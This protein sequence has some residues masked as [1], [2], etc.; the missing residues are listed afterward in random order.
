[1]E[2]ACVNGHM[3]CVPSDTAAIMT[4]AP[5]RELPRRA[6]CRPQDG[7]SAIEW[8]SKSY[9]GDAIVPMNE[10]AFP[11]GSIRFPPTAKASTPLRADLR[12]I[13][14]GKRSGASTDHSSPPSGSGL[15]M[16]NDANGGAGFD[17]G[18]PENPK[19]IPGATKRPSL[20]RLIW[21]RPVT[22]ANSCHCPRGAIRSRRQAPPLPLRPT[23]P[24]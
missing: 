7:P 15:Q 13:S 23:C 10:L 5:N 20:D 9:I 16:P 11:S 19:P 17:H 14:H 1:M 8:I 2:F 22:I 18:E 21:L 12:G 6:R 24:S 4:S 3:Q